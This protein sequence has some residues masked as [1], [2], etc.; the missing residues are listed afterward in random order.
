MTNYISEVKRSISKE[1]IWPHIREHSKLL[2]PCIV[3]CCVGTCSGN[4]N[5]WIHSKPNISGVHVRPRTCT[6]LRSTEK[7]RKNELIENRNK[8]HTDL[9]SWVLAIDDPEVEW[10]WCRQRTTHLSTG[11]RSSFAKVEIDWNGWKVD[12]RK[13]KNIGKSVSL[14][15]NAGRLSIGCGIIWT[16]AGECAKLERERERERERSNSFSQ[17]QVSEVCL[18]LTSWDRFVDDQRQGV[19]VIFQYVCVCVVH[20]VWS[21]QFWA[22]LL[23]PTSP[24]LCLRFFSLAFF[25]AVRRL[26]SK[27]NRSSFFSITWCFVSTHFRN[28]FPLHPPLI[29]CS[30]VCG[31]SFENDTTKGKER[32]TD[33]W[34]S[35]LSCSECVGRSKVIGERWTRIDRSVGRQSIEKCSNKTR[36]RI[37]DKSLLERR[38]GGKGK[39]PIKS[40]LP[41]TLTVWHTLSDSCASVV[42]VHAF[43]FSKKMIYF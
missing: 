3:G 37:D 18:H 26:I 6:D 19:S 35:S 16:I 30:S 25:V 13:Q 22:R 24:A 41:H 34:S 17:Q 38:K 31:F 21:G 10:P 29:D 5:T 7:E 2:P 43:S 42:C 1:H 20:S 32:P 11:E 15:C 23:S 12:F 8:L 9:D 40:Q 14:C 27:M 4:R 39:D 36:I 33:E 28:L